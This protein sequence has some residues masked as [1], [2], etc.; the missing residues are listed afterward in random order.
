[1][2]EEPGAAAPPMPT[3]PE[4]AVQPIP[5]DPQ[6][7]AKVE[8]EFVDQGAELGPGQQAQLDNYTDNATIAVFSEESQPAVLQSLQ[9]TEDP[10]KNVAST[11]L[12]VHKQLEMG[13]QKSGEKMSEITM[14]L[15]ASHL[16]AELIVLADAAGL[17]KLDEKQKIEAFR[18]AMMSYF[19]SGLN[20]G[21]IDPVELQK[22]LEPI[23][24]D[25]QRAYGLN[26]M[27]Q[28]GI[29]KTAPPSGMNAQ[30]QQQPPQG[31]ILG[32]R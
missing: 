17:Y 9:A 19:N 24:T 22:T 26:G 15:G 6:T 11:V 31:G 1:M 13:M 8:D 7:V 28:A 21:S 27:E 32:G 25:E 23:M 12:T 29:S 10:V 18:R 4:A 30:P 14:A 3:E 2:M 20:D 5:T 16:T